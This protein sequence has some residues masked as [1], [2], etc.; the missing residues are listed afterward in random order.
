MKSIQPL[1]TT[2][3]LTITL[4]AIL[5]AAPPVRAD[6]CI[7]SR[8]DQAD[9]REPEQKAFIVFD[10]GVENL[11]L[12]VTYEGAVDDFVWLV[13]VPG[14]AGAVVGAPDVGP[15]WRE[16]AENVANGEPAYGTGA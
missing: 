8:I 14:F 4:L 11:V 6:G 12:S 16:M 3:F 5:A 9:I 1:A 10:E 7:A 2:S 15:R 13:P